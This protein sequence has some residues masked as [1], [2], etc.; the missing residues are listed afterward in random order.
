MTAVKRMLRGNAQREWP[1]LFI[2]VRDA[3]LQLT[4][5]SFLSVSVC[6]LYYVVLVLLC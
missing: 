6:L 4:G 3:R 2:T 5:M 1:S